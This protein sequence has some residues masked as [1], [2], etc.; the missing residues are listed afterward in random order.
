[1]SGKFRIGA[2]VVLGVALVAS[3]FVLRPASNEQAGDGTLAI[4]ATSKKTYI[5][6]EDSN[7]NNI[8]DW[9]EE[10]SNSSFIK[11]LPQIKST[12][13]STSTYESSD[14]LTGKFAESFLKDYMSAKAQGAGAEESQ[15]VI[16]EKAMNS[17][18]HEKTDPTPI[19]RDEI[20][21]TPTTSENLRA[22]GNAVGRAITRNI[23]SAEG[24]LSIW[25]RAVENEDIAMLAELN[26]IVD[27]YER[28]F[29]ETK[30][31]VVPTSLAGMHL[32]LLNS[33]QLVHRDVAAMREV[34]NDPLYAILY[35][36][37]YA[38]DTQKLQSALRAIMQELQKNNITFTEDEPG[39]HLE[40]FAP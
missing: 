13:A 12:T 28:M 11:R 2:A 36:Q 27:A 9:R 10:L 16:I 35:A 32:D 22:Y 6:S 34:F 7:S 8:P 30:A 29:I 19:K 3:A 21:T 31:A 1:M 24:E 5:P 4:V 20:A 15:S 33:Y 40:Q 25:E 18:A 17:L 23:V 26:P 38:D 39:H 14:T 37:S